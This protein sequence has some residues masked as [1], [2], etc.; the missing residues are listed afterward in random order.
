LQFAIEK[1][2]VEIVDLPSYTMVIFHSHVNVY[3]RVFD[4]PFEESRIV[5]DS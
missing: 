3:Q 5:E 2:P 4:V 1:A